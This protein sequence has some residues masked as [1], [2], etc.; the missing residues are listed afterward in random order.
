MSCVTS[1]SKFSSKYRSKTKVVNTVV[2]PGVKT[3]RCTCDWSYAPCYCVKDVLH[4][5]YRM[6]KYS[7]KHIS[8][9]SKGTWVKAG[10]AN[11]DWAMPAIPV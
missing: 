2:Q 8:K 11:I 3:V 10:L 9:H 7:S 4:A 5:L 6:S 1:N